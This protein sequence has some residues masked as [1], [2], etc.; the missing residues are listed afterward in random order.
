M[1]FKSLELLLVILSL[2]SPT[3]PTIYSTN[4]IDSSVTPIESAKF[5]CDNLVK[6]E[7]YYNAAFPDTVPLSAS[8]V[9][10]FIPLYIENQ[11][12]QIE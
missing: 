1:V 10:D 11:G 9:D 4:T 3:A 5:I 7:D 6:F 8:S 12:E 2:S